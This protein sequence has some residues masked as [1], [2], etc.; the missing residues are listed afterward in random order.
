MT[1]PTRTPSI[2]STTTFMP[3]DI[4]IV[5][6]PVEGGSSFL[7]LLHEGPRDGE[8]IESPDYQTAYLRHTELDKQAKSLS[9]QQAEGVEGVDKVLW[10]DYSIQAAGGPPPC[11]TPPETGSK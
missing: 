10:L 1:H 5:T 8:A 3:K 6:E 11:P 9:T 7:T 4:H 2:E